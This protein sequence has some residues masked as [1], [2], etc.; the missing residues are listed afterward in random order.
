MMPMR[1]VTLQP[2]IRAAGAENEA[3]LAKHSVRCF[4]LFCL[5][6]AAERPP[7]AT[8][9]TVVPVPRMLAAVMGFLHGRATAAH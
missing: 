4:L 1:V 2:G 5:L 7:S 3:P 9:P 8:H 6:R